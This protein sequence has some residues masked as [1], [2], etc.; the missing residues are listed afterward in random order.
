M[1][2]AGTCTPWHT[3]RSEGSLRW[4]CFY[5][6]DLGMELRLSAL[7]ASTLT[8]EPSH[9]PCDHLEFL[10]LG[11]L[12]RMQMVLMERKKMWVEGEPV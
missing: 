8:S 9:Q 7:A 10:G 1:V 2:C 6:V 3:W 4:F 5:H 11:Q 12:L